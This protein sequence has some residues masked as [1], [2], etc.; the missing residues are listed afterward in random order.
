MHSK[1]LME[2]IYIHT[3][4]KSR[5]SLEL[6]LEIQKERLTIFYT[7]GLRALDVLK[8]NLGFDRKVFC[9]ES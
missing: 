9:R 5:G 2:L 1:N 4:M 7:S 8:N 6:A 3:R